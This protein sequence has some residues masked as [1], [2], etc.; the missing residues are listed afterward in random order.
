V[1]R[2]VFVDDP[3]VQGATV[4][5]SQ[6]EFEPETAQASDV[7]IV[8]G[9]PPF[10]LEIGRHRLACFR[11]MLIDLE[12]IVDTPDMPVLIKDL[13]ITDRLFDQTLHLLPL[14][15]WVVT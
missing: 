1:N 13:S 12:M 2:S 3:E 5:K 15:Q 11:K 7:E 4:G 14:Y 10:H 9:D 6:R 8:C